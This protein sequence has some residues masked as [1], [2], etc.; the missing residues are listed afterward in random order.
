[1]RKELGH[2]EEGK[3]KKGRAVGDKA[4]PEVS[5]KFCKALNIRQRR[6][7]AFLRKFK[8]R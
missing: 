2:E 6:W 5:A 7:N 1:M 8:E 4:V 3:G